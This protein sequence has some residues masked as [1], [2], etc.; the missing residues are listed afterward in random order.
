M[1]LV[2]DAGGA[3]QNRYRGGRAVDEILADEQVGRGNCFGSDQ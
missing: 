1:V 2:M 3:V